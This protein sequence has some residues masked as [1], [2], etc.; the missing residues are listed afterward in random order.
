MAD[1]RCFTP[2]GIGFTN[3]L[4]Q[5]PHGEDLL[6]RFFMVGELVEDGR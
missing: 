5:A 1:I 4:A 3:S 2:Y 6:G